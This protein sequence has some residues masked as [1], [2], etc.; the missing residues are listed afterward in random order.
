MAFKSGILYLENTDV[1]QWIN[2]TDPYDNTTLVNTGTQIKILSGLVGND[3]FGYSIA[4]GSGR[5]VVG[6]PYED[7]KGTSSG[8]TYIYDLNGTQLKKITASDGA[9]YDRFG[10]SVAVGSGRIV[11]GA[12]GDDENGLYSGS[13]YIYDLNGNQLNKI[14]ASDGGSY[15]YFEWSVAVGSGRIVIGAHYEDNQGSAYI[16]NLNGNQL[17]KIT[18]SDGGLYNYFG[19]LVAVGSGRIVIGAHYEDN[20]GSAYIYE[21]PENPIHLLDILN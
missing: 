1:Q 6:E 18:A 11:V 4:V 20:Q 14:T 9:T 19:W 17:Q 7:D 5:I 13:A 8:S 10:S 2:T 15:N 16:Y 12:Y 3:G 21:L